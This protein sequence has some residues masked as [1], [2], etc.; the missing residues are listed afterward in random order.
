MKMR[1][2]DSIMHV[3]P[4]AK[5]TFINKP[6]IDT[7]PNEKGGVGVYVGFRERNKSKEI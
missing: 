6:V 1:L 5:D 3:A 4:T 7:A 2:G